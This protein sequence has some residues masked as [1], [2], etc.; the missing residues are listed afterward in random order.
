MKVLVIYLF[1]SKKS[2]CQKKKSRKIHFSKKN[3]I[4]R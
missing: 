3:K 1:E 2:V 4:K